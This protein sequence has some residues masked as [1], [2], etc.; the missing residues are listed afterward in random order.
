MNTIYMMPFYN[1]KFLLNHHLFQKL[2]PIENSKFNHLINTYYP[3]I[4]E[5]QHVEYLIEMEVR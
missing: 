4:R 3:L 5:S 2:K 1:N